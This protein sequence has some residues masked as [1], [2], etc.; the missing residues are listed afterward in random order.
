[1][2]D[3]FGLGVMAVFVVLAGFAHT[4]PWHIVCFFLFVLH[5]K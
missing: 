3:E 2:V 5:A 1:M 4:R